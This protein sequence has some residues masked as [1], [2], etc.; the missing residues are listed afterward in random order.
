MP[1]RHL[2]GMNSLPDDLGSRLRDGL[3]HGAAPELSTDMVTGA[4]ERPAPKLRNP[5]RRVQFAGGATALVAVVAVTA[6]VLGSGVQRAPLFTA[7]ASSA[8]SGSASA[9]VPVSGLFRIWA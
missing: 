5:R 9:S 6:V 8:E 2:H 3:N 1:S 7:A 4:S